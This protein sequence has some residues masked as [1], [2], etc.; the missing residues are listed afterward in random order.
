MGLPTGLLLSGHPVSERGGRRG[1]VGIGPNRINPWTVQSSAQGHSQYL[2][3]LHG[4]EAKTRGLVLAYDVRQFFTNSKFDDNLPNPVRNL[5]CKDLALAAAEVYC[6]N[7]LK[8]YLFDDIRTTPEL[9]FAIR[10][11]KAIG[12]DMFSASHNPPEHNGKKVY[13]EFGGQ[14]IPPHDE[15][16]VSEVTKNVSAIH[17]VSI[18]EA[19]NQRLLLR[20]GKRDRRSLLGCGGECFT[21]TGARRLN[22]LHSA[23]RVW[24]HVRRTDTEETRL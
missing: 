11:L 20:I 12:G 18:T 1:E 13:D 5:N 24:I 7:Q 4:E 14:L 15:D 2:L 16:L 17:Q 22:R 21:L 10:H 23:A 3:K 9:S 19:E 6:A 8:V